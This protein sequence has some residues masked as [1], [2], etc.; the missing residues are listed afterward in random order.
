MVLAESSDTV[1]V[2]GAQIFAGLD[3]VFAALGG[4]SIDPTSEGDSAISRRDLDSE[5]ADRPAAH[6]ILPLEDLHT[7]HL[8][9]GT[10]SV[11][12]I[13]LYALR[14]AS[15][16]HGSGASTASDCGYENQ[17]KESHE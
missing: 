11:E 2:V 16:G 5:D 1:G 10:A 9:P 4:L 15:D 7:R 8:D 12:E 13:E 17:R 6:S 14:A 3:Q